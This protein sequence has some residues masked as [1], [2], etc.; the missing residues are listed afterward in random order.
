LGRVEP[1][2]VPLA[3]IVKT[4]RFEV[5]ATGEPHL[6]MQPGLLESAC[7]RPRNIWAYQDEDDV[8]RLAVALAAGIARNHAFQQGNKRTG[9]T[10]AIMFL[11]TNGYL[12]TMPNEDD[13]L[14][15]WL[16]SV[17]REFLSEGDFAERIRPFVK[18]EFTGT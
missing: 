6:L 11:E 15:E 9:A 17:T 12:W 7:A 3:A 10:C 1:L 4:N 16:E 14:G 2:W 13:R 18:S 5:E 8:V